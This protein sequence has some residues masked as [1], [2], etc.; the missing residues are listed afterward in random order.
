MTPPLGSGVTLDEL[1]RMSVKIL[2]FRHDCYNCNPVVGFRDTAGW[3]E[4]YTPWGGNIWILEDTGASLKELKHPVWVEAQRR[5]SRYDH[6]QH[7]RLRL[8]FQD[9]NDAILFKLAL[10]T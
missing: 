1:F 4:T 7:F 2:A 5:T 3:F 8:R 10:D 9:R 6:R